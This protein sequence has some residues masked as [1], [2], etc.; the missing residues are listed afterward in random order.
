M[1]D[2][3]TLSFRL[4]QKNYSAEKRMG[5]FFSCVVTQKQMFDR[6]GWWAGVGLMG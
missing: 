5:V 1:F 4:I 6:L 3:S 2:R